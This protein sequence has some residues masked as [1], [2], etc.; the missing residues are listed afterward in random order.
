MQFHFRTFRKILA[1]LS[2]TADYLSA[3]LAYFLLM[4]VTGNILLGTDPFFD[5]LSFLRFF[6]IAVVS[7]VAVGF[8]NLY[9]VVPL[10]RKSG[11]FVSVFSGV[12]IYVASALA[13][14][15]F[16]AIMERA[17]MNVFNAGYRDFYAESIFFIRFEFLPLTLFLFIVSFP[18]RIIHVIAER[19][20]Q[21]NIIDV[22]FDRYRVPHEEDRVFMFMDLHASTA[23]A[24]KLGHLR[25]HQMLDE[26]FHDISDVI[27]QYH[28]EVYQYVGDA[29]V[30]TW[31]INTG[32]EKMNCVRCF[33]D[34]QAVM[35]G[36]AE[37]YWNAYAFKPWFK[38]GIHSGKVIAGEV[39]DLKKE[40]A[41]HGVAVNIAS[42]IQAS[43][44]DYNAPLLVS[45]ELFL[46]FP[47][48]GLQQIKSEF[49]GCINVK[50]RENRICLYRID[51]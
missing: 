14:I 32:T 10:A 30:V 27:A 45:E 7:S 40:I 3:F 38:A 13:G 9:A 35:N 17:V 8:A 16:V 2:I 18:I 36:M 50:G 25:Y 31:D 6:A 28:G 11:F 24:E 5:F 15:M 46:S 47:I 39:G 34:I 23:A 20:G 4:T 43:C 21:K 44:L 26:V 1:A 51:P 48:S 41:Y 42:R 29:V 22:V 49:I 37:K 12:L 19:I 33:F